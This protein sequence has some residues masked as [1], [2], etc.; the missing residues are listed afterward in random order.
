MTR[1]AAFCGNPLHLKSL[2][3]SRREAPALVLA[4]YVQLPIRTD[5]QTVGRYREMRINIRAIN[6]ASDSDDEVI[7]I[8]DCRAPT[9]ASSR[10]G[11]VLTG[12]SKRLACGQQRFI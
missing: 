9:S 10:P 12:R 7:G 5:R 4:M 8:H 6:D 11:F 3:S 2:P 1:L